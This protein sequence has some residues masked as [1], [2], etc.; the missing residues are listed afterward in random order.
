MKNIIFDFDGVILDSVPVKTEAF[1][2]LFEEFSADKVEQLIKY[3]L[4]NG[5]KSRYIKIKYFFNDI[6][7]QDISE[8]DIL[9]YANKYSFLTKKELSQSKY[10][11]EDTI[12]FIKKN[13]KKYNMH[14]ASGADEN[15]LKF[16]CDSLEL[17][18]YF[19]SVNGSPKIKS[20][21]VK[22]ILIKNNYKKSETILIGDSVNDFEAADINGIEFYGFNNQKLEKNYNYIARYE[23]D[24]KN[25]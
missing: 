17:K 23:K 21:I 10:L 5:G 24:L 25:V 4:L 6:L 9:N 2:K 16:I 19:L 20:E 7:N 1:R 3:H 8:K 15:D 18:Q 11:I 22:G 13:Y 14:I 12:N